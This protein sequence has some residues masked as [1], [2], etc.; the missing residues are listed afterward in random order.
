MVTV[1]AVCVVVTFADWLFELSRSTQ[2]ILQDGR[3]LLEVAAVV[4]IT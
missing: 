3:V 2:M 4:T 1:F